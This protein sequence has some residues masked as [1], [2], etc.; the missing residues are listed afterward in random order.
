MTE[1][2]RFEL[3]GLQDP[4]VL[5]LLQEHLQDMRAISP[6]ESVHALDVQGLMQPHIQFWSAWGT[7]AGAE[8][9]AGVCA[10]KRLSGTEAELKSMRVAASRR[11]QGDAQKLIDFVLQQGRQAGIT[12]IHLET[13]TET[14][15]APARRFYERNGFAYCPPF[16]DYALDPNSCFMTRAL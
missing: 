4:R 2:L 12:H 7:E 14:Y 16:G 6:P 3:G 9:L 5:A 13:G 10:L 11:G 15:F 1:T 8:Q